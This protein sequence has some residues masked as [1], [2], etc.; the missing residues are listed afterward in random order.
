MPL[1]MR[2]PTRI[3]AAEQGTTRDQFHH[4][5]DIAPT[6]YEL[7]GVTP[8]TTYRGRDQLPITGTSLAYAIEDASAPTTK[9]VQYFEMMGHRGL[10]LDG[11]KAVTRHQAGTPF[12]DDQWE[13][14]DLTTDRSECNDLA[15]AEPERLAAL[16]ERWWEEADRHGVLPLDDRTIELFGARFREG[17]PHRPERTYRYIPPVTPLPV[18]AGPAIGGR[19]W[20]MVASVDRGP[21]DEGVL[22]ATGTENSGLS[23]FVQGGRLVFDYNCFGDHHVVESNRP[24]PDGPSRLGVSFRKRAF[25]DLGRSGADATISIAGEPVGEVHVP[26]AMFVMSSLGPSIGRDDGSPVSDRYQGSF[27]FTGRLHEVVV[28]L[29]SRHRP[30]GAGDDEATGEERAAMGRQ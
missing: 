15:E 25:G 30:A 23:L 4:V 3:P 22:Y 10:W 12:E 8:P 11:W 6:V 19:D 16:I 2:W 24:V 14:Y 20:D 21:A 9:A 27:P 13:L 5:N 26:F 28:E 17:S 7:T 1:I 29:V 18:Q